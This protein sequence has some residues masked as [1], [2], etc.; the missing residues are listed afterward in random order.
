MVPQPVTQLPTWQTLQALQAQIDQLR[1]RREALEDVGSGRR[2]TPIYLDDEPFGN[3]VP[4]SPLSVELENAPWLRR[5]NAT[6]L[7]HYDGESDPKEFLMKFEAAVES[8][9]GDSTTKAEAFVLALK[10]PV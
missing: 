9:G 7:P 4:V 8:N 10:G 1:Q 2:G 6:T 3:I 5:F